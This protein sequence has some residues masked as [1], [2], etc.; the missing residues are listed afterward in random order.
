MPF[1]MPNSA[2]NLSAAQIV[3]EIEL[4]SDLD[5]LSL[6]AEMVLCAMGKNHV[7]NESTLF[8]NT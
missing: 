5:Q 1:G 4:F 3:H 2:A 6:V 7:S 8:I